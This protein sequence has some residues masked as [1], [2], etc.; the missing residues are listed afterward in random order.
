MAGIW[1]KTQTGPIGRSMRRALIF[2]SYGVDYLMDDV[3]TAAAPLNMCDFL[4]LIRRSE[5]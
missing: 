2:D 4:S 1:E 5:G 3:P